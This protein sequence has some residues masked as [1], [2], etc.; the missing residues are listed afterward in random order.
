MIE[1]EKLVKAYVAGGPNAVDEVSFTVEEGSFYTLV[2][3]SGCGKTTTLRSIAGLE[4]PTGG[5]IKLGGVTVHDGRYSVPTHQRDIGMVFQNYAVWPHMN[6]FDNVAF[7]LRAAAK[8]SGKNVASGTMKE[9]VARALDVVGLSGLESRMSTQLSGGQQQ[10]LS[11]ARAVVREP[12]VLLLDEPLSNLDAKLR[13]RMR[14]DLKI[15]HKEL[16]IT[17][18]FVT[19]DQVEALSMSDRIGVMSAGKIVQEGTPEDVYHRPVNEFVAT[20]IGSTNL[21]RGTVIGVEGGIAVVDTSMGVIRGVA[22]GPAR[23]GEAVSVGIRPENIYVR[24]SD[25]PAGHVH[26]DA[27]VLPAHVVIGLFAGSFT[28]YE[29]EVRGTRLNVRANSLDMVDPSAEIV[30]ELPVDVCRVF[31]GDDGKGGWAAPAPDDEETSGQRTGSAVE[32]K[33]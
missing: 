20:F 12:A 23:M 27:T 22:V 29:V 8:Q 19:H 10:R 13:E 15:L 5:T 11:F 21:V 14:R 7:P 18:L 1:V 33:A 26:G 28:E 4:R 17:S 2:G 16:G 25:Q 3:P 30:V 6:V 9:R 24:A 31:C 32:A